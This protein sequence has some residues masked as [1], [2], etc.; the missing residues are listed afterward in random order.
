M[1]LSKVNIDT[2]NASNWGMWAAQVRSAARILNCWDV[3]KGEVVVPLTMLPTYQLLTRPTATRCHL[4]SHRA[5][6]LDQ[7]EQHCP[8]CYTRKDKFSNMA[9]ICKSR[10]CRHLMDC[11]GN[12]TWQSW[13][14]HYLSPSSEL[15]QSTHDQLHSITP[16]N[17]KFPRKLWADFGKQSLMNIWGHCHIHFLFFSTHIIPGPRIAVSDINR[18]YNEV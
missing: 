17:P 15:I 11:L 13:G 1:D 9:R 10:H 14:G 4:T 3:I 5:S 7:E 8:W 6:S 18:G 2:L 16:P 12:K